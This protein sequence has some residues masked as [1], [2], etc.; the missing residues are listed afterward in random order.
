MARGASTSP[1]SLIGFLGVPS[2]IPTSGQKLSNWKSDASNSI[3]A[4]ERVWPPSNR[5]DSPIKHALTPT[6]NGTVGVAGKLS[7]EYAI[8]W[9][10][11][12]YLNPF[13]SDAI[14]LPEEGFYKRFT[15]RPIDSTSQ[16]VDV[17]AQRIAIGQVFSP[18]FSLEH[19]P[20]ND[21]W[22]FTHENT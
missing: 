3:G 2:P 1:T 12:R 8:T 21:F 14:S 18:Q 9:N 20:R 16:A 13:L 4:V 11:F 19:F 7:E 15:R 10:L 5:T 22:G 17:T 6:F